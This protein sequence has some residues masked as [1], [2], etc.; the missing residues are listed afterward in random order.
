MEYKKGKGKNL[1]TFVDSYVVVDIE[2]TGLQPGDDEII[3]IGAIKVD[4]YGEVTTFDK[5][6]KAAFPIPPFIT[7]LTG[8]HDG[9]LMDEGEE[10]EEVLYAFDAFIGDAILIGHN[11]TFDIHFINHNYHKYL[12]KDLSN[13]YID[14]LRLARRYLP[15][16]PNHK[17]ATL[18][19]HI[20]VDTSGHHR[21]L[22]DVKMTLEVYS[23]L[24]QRFD[25]R[26]K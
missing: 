1:L 18:A 8:I 13:D 6:I 11:V 17:L 22:A 26:S 24:Q 19:N 25:T 14:T 23:Y 9:M 15:F 2:T 20:Q 21:A 3:E 16:L 5:L 7:Q 4:A 10:I 12:Q